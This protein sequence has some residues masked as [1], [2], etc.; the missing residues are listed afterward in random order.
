MPDGVIYQGHRGR[1]K[2]VV[3]LPAEERAR[4]K[5]HPAIHIHVACY[6]VDASPKR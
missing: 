6:R 3:A 4:L 2:P 1:P 5:T